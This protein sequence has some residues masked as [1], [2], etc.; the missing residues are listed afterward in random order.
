MLVTRTPVRDVNIN[1]NGSQCSR[2]SC[3]FK[4][5]RGDDALSISTLFHF[6]YQSAFIYQSRKS[7]FNLALHRSP[8]YFPL[9]IIIG[10][11]ARSELSSVSWCRSSFQLKELFQSGHVQLHSKVTGLKHITGMHRFSSK[12]HHSLKWTCNMINLSKT[13]SPYVRGVAPYLYVFWCGQR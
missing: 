5:K 3:H 6:R 1:T 13:W 10:P 4:A 8:I 9:L 2:R 7:F 12:I 11:G